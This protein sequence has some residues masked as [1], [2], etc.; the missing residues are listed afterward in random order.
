MP[1]LLVR[2]RTGQNLWGIPRLFFSKKLGV[3]RFLREKNRGGNLFSK[4]FRTKRFFASKIG[5]KTFFANNIKFG[6]LGFQFSKNGIFEGQKVIYV[7]SSESDMFIGVYLFVHVSEF[8]FIRK[9]M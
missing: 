5:A 6:N 1:H 9:R 2:T 7:G 8:P 3:Q 4:E